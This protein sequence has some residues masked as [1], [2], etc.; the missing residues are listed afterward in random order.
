MRAIKWHKEP[1][2]QYDKDVEVVQT[3]VGLFGNYAII[4]HEDTGKLEKVPM[5]KLKILINN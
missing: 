3:G 4:L 1:G 5:K 2:L